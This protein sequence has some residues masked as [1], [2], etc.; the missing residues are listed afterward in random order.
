MDGRL[1]DD[2]IATR[3]GAS[4]TEVSL[5][6]QLPSTT[7]CTTNFLD[8]LAGV[9]VASVGRTHKNLLRLYCSQSTVKVQILSTYFPVKNLRS[10]DDVAL[11]LQRQLSFAASPLRT[12]FSSVDPTFRPPPIEVINCSEDALLFEPSCGKQTP[13][14]S[15]LGLEPNSYSTILIF[16]SAC[17]LLCL[18]FGVCALC[19]RRWWKNKRKV[20]DKA[21]WIVAVQKEQALE[22]EG[23]K[24]RP[25]KEGSEESSEHLLPLAIAIPSLP[26]VS[27]ATPSR[28]PLSVPPLP[29]PDSNLYQDYND[30][31][32]TPPSE[33][34]R[35]MDDLTSEH[36]TFMLV[37]CRDVI[38]DSQD[39]HKIDV[40][41]A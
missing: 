2:N 8:L 12:N 33:A 24:R 28:S 9:I 19:L 41:I 32:A 27:Q 6:F 14:S 18:L 16:V 30:Y 10:S 1:S 36:E 23:A 15:W 37:E 26:A 3:K 39:C 11:E 38:L 40:G 17:V 13:Q 25:T 31:M 20:E 35:S 7:V 4:A 34:N 5:R 29:D 21:K 22:L